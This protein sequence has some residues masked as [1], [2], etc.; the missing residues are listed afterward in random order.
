MARQTD[1]DIKYLSMREVMEAMESLSVL[2]NT[3][4]YRFV[5]SE[6]NVIQR[7]LAVAFG[8]GLGF[9]SCAT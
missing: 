3:H 1:R 9:D 7:K 4:R 6:L 2:S 8:L 5:L